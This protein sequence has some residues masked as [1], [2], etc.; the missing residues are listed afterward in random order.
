MRWPFTADY[1]GRMTNFDLQIGWPVLAATVVLCGVTAI[2]CGMAPAVQAARTDVLPSLKLEGLSGRRRR[3]YSRDGLVMLQLAMSIVLLVGAA[4]LIRSMIDLQRGPGIDANRVALLRLRPSLIGSSG[5]RAHL[6]QRAVIKRLQSLPGIEAAAAAEN[7]PLFQGGVDVTVTP[8]GSGQ[9]AAV[10]DVR[11][12]YVGDRYFDVIGPDAGRPRLQP[13]R[14]AGL[15]E[16]A[17]ANATLAAALGGDRAVGMLVNVADR[18]TRSSAS[19]RR[20]NT[21]RRSSPPCRFCI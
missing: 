4:L 11:A 9:P 15:S 7:L 13:H 20:P 17:I 12:S 21:T 19:C 10:P 1:A 8:V 5:A 6:F 14:L 3:T 16:G 18:P 2:L